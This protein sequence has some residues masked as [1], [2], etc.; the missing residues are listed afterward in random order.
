MQT[1]H[2]DDLHWKTIEP[3][4]SHSKWKQSITMPQ[5]PNLQ[6]Y[7]ISSIFNT[8]FIIDGQEKKLKKN[9]WLGIISSMQFFC[10]KDWF[11]SNLLP[12][13]NV[14]MILEDKVTKPY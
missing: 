4:T 1:I 5:L 11:A 13:F 9:F 8:F 2:D 6:M 10:I 14:C 3:K 7:K 12:L